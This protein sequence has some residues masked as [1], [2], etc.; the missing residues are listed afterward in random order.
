MLVIAFYTTCFC[1]VKINEKLWLSYFE[2]SGAGTVDSCAD[3]S[4]DS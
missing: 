2:C 3:F 4:G 1:R